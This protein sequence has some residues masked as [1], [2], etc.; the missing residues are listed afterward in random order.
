MCCREMSFEIAVLQGLL[1]VID[2]II[3]K[4]EVTGDLFRSLFERMDLVRPNA[5]DI[6]LT[7]IPSSGNAKLAHHLIPKGFHLAATLINFFNIVNCDQDIDNGLCINTGDRG[8]A[9]MVD[10]NDILAE[11]CGDER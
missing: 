7:K 11:S 9:D 2:Q 6:V 8:A 3:S 1:R 4:R 5:F 10:G